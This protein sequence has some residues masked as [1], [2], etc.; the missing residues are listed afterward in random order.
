MTK[1]RSRKTSSSAS[2]VKI[3][4]AHEKW[5]LQECLNLLA[6]ENRA[7]NA[8]RGMLSS[9]LSNR[10]TSPDQFYMGTR[11]I[12]EVQTRAEELAKGLFRCDYA[13]V[14]PLSG[15]VADVIV[16]SLL[17]YRG[18]KIMA[19]A[20]AH[21]GY[22][23]I[24]PEGYPKIYGL[25]VTEFPFDKEKFNIDTTTAAAEIERVRPKIVV[26]GASFI[27]FPHPLK[28]LS[29]TCHRIGAHVVYDGSHVLGLIAGGQFQDP[30]REGADLL[31]GS[32]HK[33]FP[34][35]QGGV[36]LT[37]KSKDLVRSKVNPAIVDNAHWNRIAALCVALE[38][39]KKFGTRYAK[40][41]ISNSQTLAKALDESGIKLLGKG[42]GFTKSH[43][44]I[45]NEDDPQKT[46][47]MARRL[48]EA[49]ILVD[50]GIRIGT[51]EETRLGMR[52]PEM[53]RIAELISRV[54]V[55]N[56]HPSKIR[57]EV[58]KLRREFLTLKF[59]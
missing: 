38:E 59:C 28:E 32:T 50:V 18:D 49:N 56:E 3:V 36:L 10:Y 33:S 24:S 21:G 6:S 42:S 53:Q 46:T 31:I 45:V 22:P 27:L 19:V 26:F 7:S 11:Y 51:S 1:L 15:H 58:R 5:R 4:K 35:P 34:G 47:R 25:H 54:W 43:Q 48:E 44:V 57:N 12:D 14:T 41:V 8:V 29:E 30:L 17:A 2:S 52:E 23:G 37:T 39:M 16:L 55:S 9:D 13:D 20:K 40:Q